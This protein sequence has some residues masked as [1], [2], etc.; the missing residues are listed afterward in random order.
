MSAEGARLL[1]DRIRD[2]LTTDPKNLTLTGYNWEMLLMFHESLNSFQT[3]VGTAEGFAEFDALHA[4]A[5]RAQ[6]IQEHYPESEVK[7]S[8][9][10]DHESDLEMINRILER[11]AMGEPN[12]PYTAEQFR[13]DKVRMCMTYLGFHYNNDDFLN[14]EVLYPQT[15]GEQVLD[16]FVA[17]VLER[18][19]GDWWKIKSNAH[20][21]ETAESEEDIEMYR[22]QCDEALRATFPDRNVEEAVFQ[23]LGSTA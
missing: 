9:L 20:E 16:R 15:P 3:N 5:K 18:A 14:L 8:M 12:N 13:D 11:L 1:A 7:I 6:L 4:I 22:V 21:I 19:G 17:D 2:D 23:F 10:F